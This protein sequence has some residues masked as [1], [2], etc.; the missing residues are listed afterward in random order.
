MKTIYCITGASGHLGNVIVRQLVR[1]Q[2]TVRVLLLDNDPAPI[3][4]G[5]AIERIYGNVTRIDSLHPFFAHKEDEELIVIHAAGIITIYSKMFPLLRKVNIEGTRNMLTLAKQYRVK[6]FVYISSVHALK[7]SYGK[8]I[9]ET[10]LFSAKAVKGPY[11]KTKAYA[12]QM[13]LDSPLDVVV[14]HPSG[15]IGPYDTGSGNMNQ[16]ILDYIDKKMRFSVAGGYDFVDVRDVASGTIKAAEIGR[17]H[18]CYILSNR[19]FTIKE[20]LAGLSIV[21]NRKPPKS[22]LS[23][24]FLGMMAPLVELFSK[25]TKKIPTLTRYSLYTIA[26]GITFSHYLASKEL[27][28]EPRHI[29]ET[30]KDTV[31]W[32]YA[33][34]EQ[35]PGLKRLYK[36]FKHLKKV[37]HKVK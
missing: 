27:G 10:K 29:M 25:M 6:R 11:A 35:K 34:R 16:M 32:I 7:E 30:L 17:D 37:T 2:K 28:Y 15:I 12:T 14:V 19:Y 20:L 4:S 8:P 24:A 3:L 22:Q 5:L 21:L 36:P 23:F 33:C 31:T 18:Q 13:V 26:S 1:D 9:I